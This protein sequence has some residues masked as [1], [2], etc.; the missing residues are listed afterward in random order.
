[1]Q[2]SMQKRKHVIEAFIYLLLFAPAGNTVF[3]P[4][5]SKDHPSWSP[6]VDFLQPSPLA[7]SPSFPC[8]FPCLVTP[9]E[10]EA[11]DQVIG[12]KGLV[13][14]HETPVENTHTSSQEHVDIPPAYL[15]DYYYF[16]LG[17]NLLL[18]L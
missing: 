15:S 8:C 7:A 12:G 13:F 17:L 6:K 9:P 11:A 18:E 5:Y 14:Q 2:K 4:I 1:M 10:R 16:F 3:C